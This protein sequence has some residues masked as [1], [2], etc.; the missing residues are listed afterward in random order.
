MKKIHGTIVA[1]A[2]IFAALGFAAPA[3]ASF[4]ECDANRACMWGNNDFQWLI[5]ERAAGGGLVN[6]TGDHN[7]QMD[8]WGNRTTR[9]A[10][11]YGSTNGSGDCQTFSAG[12]RDNNVASW[13][14][15][16]ITSWKTNGGC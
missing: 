12:S 4:A 3:S 15:D 5:G 13:N 6:L 11:G 7:N 8:S 16:E 10:A 9:N 2:V 1:G 14:S